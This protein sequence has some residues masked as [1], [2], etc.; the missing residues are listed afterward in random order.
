MSDSPQSRRLGSSLAGGPVSRRQ[1]LEDAA[2]A[3]AAASVAGTLARHAN[4]ATPRACRRRR[5]AVLG[6]GPAGLTAAHELAERGFEVTVWERK[7][8]GGKARSIPVPGTARGGRSP[9]PGEHGFRFF[10]GFYQHVPDTMRRIPF[11]RNPNG[12]WDNLVSTPETRLSRSGG[13]EDLRLPLEPDPGLLDVDS[14]RRSLI[15]AFEEMMVLPPHE[16]EFFVNRLLVFFTSSD[17]RRYGQ[18]EHLSWKDFVRAEGKSEEYQ[19]FLSAGLTRTLVAAKEHLASTRTIGNMAEAFVYNAMGRGND[20][21]LDRVLNAPTNEAWIDPWVRY[22]REL[23]VRFRV[24]WEIEAIEV[25]NGKVDSARAHGPRA[26]RRIVDA[27]WFVCALPA[28]CA[29]RLWSPRILRLDPRLEAMNEL[30]VDWMT[31]IQFYLNRETSLAKG[32]LAFIDSPWALTALTQGQFW[33]GRS[34]PR[35]YGDGSVRDCLSVDVSDWDTPG[36]VYGKPGKRCRKQQVAREVWEQIKA[37]VND[38]GERPLTDDMLHSYF[39][40]PAI[41]WSRRKRRNRNS[42]KLLINTVGSWE[43]RPTAQTEI[44]NLFLAGDYV[45]TDIDLATM[46]SANESARAAVNALLDTVDSSA[47]RCAMY[48]LYDPPEFE[49]L[50]RIDEARFRAGQPNALDRP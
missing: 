1:L 45:Q 31:G 35:D 3:A 19:R 18:W 5:V 26:R 42:E 8:L 27:D 4:A 22:L 44:P 15:S 9:L 23:G 13:R 7:A 2:A 46:E 30:F 6:A 10:P 38:T 12:V 25:R 43:Q 47:D 41:R 48:K 34:F 14:L 32:H 21:D 39:L 28:E 16:L 36:I 37:H 33:E 17:A 24:G 50:K 11:A 40:D 29:R 49:L 20:G